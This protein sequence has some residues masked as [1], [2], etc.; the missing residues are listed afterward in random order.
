[1]KRGLDQHQL[2]CEI[3]T[4]S[5]PP[6]VADAFAKY[7]A[8]R[9]RKRQKL[10]H[11]Q[12]TVETPGAGPSNIGDYDREITE[13]PPRQPTPQP[14]SPSPEP[15]P[16]LSAAGRIVRKKRL[17]WKLLQSLPE[18]PPPAPEPPCDDPDSTPPPVESAFTWKGIKTATNSFGLFREYPTTPTHNPDDAIT[19]ANLSDS[20]APPSVVENALPTVSRMALPV[21]DGEGSSIGIL[22]QAAVSWLPFS[23]ST[24]FGLMNWMWTGS[25]LKS[26]GEMA[27]LVLFLRSDDFRKEDLEN[28]DISRETAKFD[29]YLE[30]ATTADSDAGTTGTSDVPKDGWREV[31]VDI[32]VPDGLPH[33]LGNAIPVFTVPGLHLRSITEVIKSVVSDTAA[34][35]F[36]YTP[37][38]QY[39]SPPSDDSTTPSQR[40]YDELYSSD[41][42]IEEHIAVQKLPPEPDCSLERVVAALMFWSDSTH[43][44]NFGTASIWPLYLFFGNQSK[45]LRGKPRTASCHH[46]AYIPKLPDLFSD[47]YHDRTGKT[48]DSDLLTH[49]RRELM[50][51]VWQLLLDKEFMHAYE[52]GIVIECPDG[53]LRRF[54]P[55]IFTYSADYPENRALLATIRNM[56]SCPCPRCLIPKTQIPELGTKRDEARRTATHRADSSPQRFTLNVAREWIYHKG[57]GVKSAAVERMLSVASLVP[58][59]NAFSVLSAFSFNIHKALVVDFM[60]EFELGT[61]KALF[62]HLIRILT[63]HGE[64]AVQELNRR[65][66]Q[67]PTF[68]RSTIRRFSDNVSAM[69]KLAARNFEDLLQCAIPVFE[70]LL[71]EPHNGEVLSL[72][73]TF[74]E[75][76]TLAKLRLHT[77]ATLE[78]LEE[79]TTQ[80]GRQLRRFESFT[81]SM[82]ATKE[83]PKEEAARGRRQAQKK[84][85]TAPAATAA[86][87]PSVA[88]STAPSTASTTEPRTAGPSTANTAAPLAKPPRK[89]K[90]FNL[91]TYKLHAL[92]DYVR[93]IKWF[94]TT[95]SYSTQP[96][97][98]E[99]LPY[100]PP[101]VHHHISPSRNFPV[102]VTRFLAET[103]GDRATKNFLPNLQEHILERLAHPEWSGNGLEFTPEE[104]GK[105]FIVGNRFYRHKVLRVNY[106]TYDV[107]RGQDSMNPRTQADIMVLPRDENASHPFEYA[108]IVGIFHVDV[109]LNTSGANRTPVSIE[110]LLVRWFHVDAAH[111]AGF[112][113]KRL[114]RIQF[115]PENDA[116]AFGFLNPD[117]VIRGAHLIPAFH[118]GGTDALLQGE[119]IARLEGE[120]DDWTYFYVNIFVD[121]DM[122]MRYAGGGVGHYQVPLAPEDDEPDLPPDVAIDESIV[123]PEE[124]GS[125]DESG[126][127][128]GSDD[129]PEDDLGVEDG[130]GGFVDEEDEEGYAP[131]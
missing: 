51:Q 8:K 102:N 58:T 80:I 15:P 126:S 22:P 127:S 91:F 25:A 106:T 4:E 112:K 100:T 109:I 90:L 35:C 63:A 78:F 54:Y 103:Q 105:V 131:L 125:S 5:A 108:R 122:Y 85:R 42:M 27:K 45:W 110:V 7:Q 77:D 70:G 11:D 124:P 69:K 61:W 47:F 130:E 89:K 30:G 96:V 87:V 101:E 19:L 21:L 38:K 29:A 2:S 28:V 46:I 111:R 120:V 76:H 74:A 62:T 68:G 115:I 20:T 16:T 71:P 107:R 67:V 92:G 56:G 81:C 64:S 14:L 1:M 55:R 95:D 98:S 60:H 129:G 65:Y 59:V 44:A 6:V 97:K 121:R 75:W 119:T 34:R 40:I 104:R 18:P 84:A 12:A 37:F 116:G 43:L 3:F 113:K 10:A 66:R 53:I 36:H 26:V 49:C 33:P 48:P 79:A 57:N 73:F 93:T 123:L 88:P 94:G 83:L 82:F 52:H 86:A 72:L 31:D 32:E 24:I 114:H 17:T 117:E 50:H 39:W 41:A 128:T 118:F 99:A 9:E 13:E 23:N